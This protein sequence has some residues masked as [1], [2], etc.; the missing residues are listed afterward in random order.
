MTTLLDDVPAGV[1]MSLAWVVQALAAVGIVAGNLADWQLVRGSDHGFASVAPFVYGI[2]GV[3][4]PLALMVAAALLARRTRAATATATVVVAL[5]AVA[6]V[7]LAVS[8]ALS[9]SDTLR[10][11]PVPV[12]VGLVFVE[13]CV[14]FGLT[15]VILVF[16]VVLRRYPAA[17]T[18]PDAG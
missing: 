4:V 13:E 3:P 6:A 12:P 18:G 7:Q 14:T 15:L 16:G 9:F 5:A 2:G 17:T 1:R 11:V 10:P 8:L